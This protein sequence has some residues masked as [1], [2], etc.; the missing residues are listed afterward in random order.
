MSETPDWLSDLAE[1]VRDYHGGSLP[2]RLQQR[3]IPPGT[4]SRPASV[5]MLFGESEEPVSTLMPPP[6]VPCADV[7]L[8]QRASTLRHHS[9]Q[10]AFPGGVQDPGDAGP[11]GTALREAEEETGLD[12]AGVQPLV[13]MPTL[14]IPPSGFV[15][16]PVLAY[17]R[18]PSPVRAVDQAETARV[19][20]IA[21]SDLVDPANRFQISYRRMFKGPA[22]TVDGMLVW[23]FTAGLL[24][25]LIAEAGWEQEWDTGDVRELDASLADLEATVIEQ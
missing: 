21:L 4:S 16:S 15:V 12:P 23:G 22:F 19:S 18:E 8:L 3:L 11:I 20:R 1:R 9:G 2:E 10:V 6:G 24:S 7:L 5:L 25:A 14:Y 13:V 17:W